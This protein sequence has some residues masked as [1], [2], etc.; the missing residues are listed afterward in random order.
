MSNVTDMSTMFYA[1]LFNQD[2]GNWDVSKV[3][4]TDSFCKFVL[5]NID[6]SP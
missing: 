4:F 5:N 6:V 2:I 1:N 3:I